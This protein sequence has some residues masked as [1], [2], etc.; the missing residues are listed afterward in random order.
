[1]DAATELAIAKVAE[2][3]HGVFAIHHLDELEVSKEERRHRIELQRWQ[4]PYDVVYRIAGAPRSWKGD[5][6]AACWAGGIRAVASHRSAAALWDLP[7]K[8]LEIAEI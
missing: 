7:G 6:L 8:R 2:E 4:S 1:M 3:H 5:V